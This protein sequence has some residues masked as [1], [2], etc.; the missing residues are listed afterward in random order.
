MATT[1]LSSAAD[2]VEESIYSIPAHVAKEHIR[3]NGAYVME[4]AAAG[5]RVNDFINDRKLPLRMPGGLDFCAQNSLYDK[6]EQLLSPFRVVPNILQGIREVIESSI[7]RPH[8]GLAKVY[9]SEILPSDTAYFF[10]QGPEIRAVYILLFTPNTRF[11]LF[12]GS[13]TKKSPGK[14]MSS[15]G[16]LT[17]PHSELEKEGIKRVTHDMA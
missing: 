12:E 17:L 10:V 11:Y 16:L 15:F 13:H 3:E 14:V 8:W 5:H 2:D 7:D 9:N 4:D 6:V 1:A